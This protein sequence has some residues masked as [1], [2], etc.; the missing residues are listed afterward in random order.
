MML[1]RLCFCALLAAAL[2]ACGAP[3]PPPAHFADFRFDRE[4]PIRLKVA[5]IDVVDAFR[6]SFQPPAVEH[7]FPV[8]PQ[9]ALE[10]LGRD[11]LQAVEP[12]SQRIARFVIE[13]AGVRESE[14]PRTPGIKGAFT[15]DQAERY[16]GHVA[17]RLE[18]ID[19]SGR[20]VRVARAEAVRTSSVAEG[21]TLN[22]RDQTW[23][24]MTRELV[25]ALDKELQRQID[26]GFYPYID[27]N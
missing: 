7:E 16:D 20:T 4:P 6:P 26:A 23:Y 14:L 3:E 13:D 11:R 25:G 1:R 8:P 24:D 12:A 5:K 2:A 19:E 17:V 18:I 15:I 27:L 10:A 9:R 22:E 21:I